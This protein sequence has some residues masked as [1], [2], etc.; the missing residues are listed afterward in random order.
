M[1]VNTV[2]MVKMWTTLFKGMVHWQMHD[3]N[4]LCLFK[5]NINI[6]F[7]FIPFFHFSIFGRRRIHK[8]IPA[9]MYES[10]RNVRLISHMFHIG[11]V[12]I[13]LGL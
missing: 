12:H 6:A 7:S 10:G 13:I 1:Y 2:K 11:I 9:N 8:I 3:N 4:C 5:R